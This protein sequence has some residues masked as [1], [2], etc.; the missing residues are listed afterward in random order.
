M[1]LNYDSFI[2]HLIFMTLNYDAFIVHL[3]QGTKYF[4]FDA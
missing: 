1:T 2:V 4:N 3:I